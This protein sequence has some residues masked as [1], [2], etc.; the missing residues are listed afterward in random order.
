MSTPRILAFAGSA[1]RESFNRRILPTAIR[2]AEAAGARVT[3]IELA[4]FPL[5][6][7]DEDL[8]SASGLP[9]NC[10][11]LK[12]MF[13]T[14]DALLIACP[15][16]NSAITPLLKNVID[17]VSR[18]RE[19]EKPLECFDQK[20]CGLLAASPGALGGL[21]GLFTVRSILSN[22]RV[23]VLPDMAAVGNAHN[24]LQGETISDERSRQ[25]VESVGRRVA[26]VA[27]ALKQH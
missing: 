8:E 5:P 7:M 2:A 15:E 22:I 19:G 21:R 17:W 10:I 6:I 27:A 13:K 18:P 1:R 4:D 14:H 16:Y 24:V 20:V 26:E 3:H 12:D 11:K 25:M 23:I 9:E